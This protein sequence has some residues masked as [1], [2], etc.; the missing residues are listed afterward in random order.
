MA[1]VNRG[2]QRLRELFKDSNKCICAPGVYDGIGARLAIAAGFE[3]IYMTGAGTSMARL[4]MADLGL[5]TQTDMIANASAIAAISPEIPLIADADTGY[6]GPIMVYRTVQAYARAGVA[7]LHLEDQ[8]QEKRCGH[9]AGKQVVES[10]VWYS[11]LRAAV[12]A[13]DEMQSD[14]MIIARTDSRATHGMGE[15]IERLKQAAQLGVDLL[16][17]EAMQSKDEFLEAHKALKSTGKPMVLN[18]LPGGN[19]PEI[20]LKEAGE[21]GFRLTLHPTVLLEP[22]IAKGAEALAHLKQHGSQ[23]P[24]GIGPRKMFSLCGLDELIGIDKKA[25]GEAY[26]GT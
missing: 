9:L 1:V 19:T 6:G 20:S 17:L 11:R 24:G 16:F 18:L 15:A 22:S 4:G 25:G 26:Q 21:V 2:A 10:Q 12:A 14:V 3:C 5:C 23:A 13:R 7:A 8:V